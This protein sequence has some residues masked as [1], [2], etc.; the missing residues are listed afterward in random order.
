MVYRYAFLFIALSGSLAAVAQK[1]TT[2]QLKQVDISDGKQGNFGAMNQVDGMMIGAGKKTEIISVEQL[3]V[4]K[5]TNNTRQ[6]YAKVAGL[7][8][9]END[10]SGLQLS[11]GGRGLDPNRTSNFN[12]RQNG[13]DISADALGYPESYYT[14]PT[15]ALRRIEIIKGAASLQYGTQF[16]GLLNFEMKQPEDAKKKLMVESRQTLGSWGFFGSFNSIGGTSADGKVSYYAFAQYKRGDGWR[17]NSGFQ[18]LNVYGDVHYHVNEKHMFG[19][20]YTHLQYLAQQPGGLDDRMFAADPRQSNR[21]RNWFAVKWN[22][23]DLEWDYRIS[24]RTRWQTR[25]Y[26]L[27]A[28]R[29][30][31]GF[32]PNRPAQPD[33]GGAR[34]LLMG[35]FQNVAM[36]SKVL[37]SYRAGKQ[38]QTLLTGVR[39]YNGHSTNRQGYVNNGSGARFSFDGEGTQMLSDYEFPN[40][41]LAW[42]AEHIVRLN[43]KWQVTPGIRVEHIRTQANGSYYNRVLDLRD[44]IVS[45]QLVEERRLLPRTF[46]IAGIGSGYRFSSRLEAYGNISQN[47][48]SVTFSDIR[49]VNPSFEIDPAISDEKG[50]SGDLGIRGNA[51]DVFRFDANVF[52]LY[53]G[54]RIGEYFYTKSNA[55]VVRRRG[56]VGVAQIYGLESFM[57][58]DVLQLWKADKK[59]ALTVYNNLSLTNARYT[60]SPIANIEGRR[61]EYVPFMNWKAGIQAGYKNIKATLQFSSLSEQYADATNAESG[62]YSGVNGIVPAYRLVDLSLSYHYKWLVL[63]GTVNNLANVPYFTRRATGYP[64]PGIIPGDGRGFYLTAGVKL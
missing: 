38:L 48:R 52:Y 43:S 32:R 41:N 16:G 64:G 42:F 18:S 23:L 40:L 15:E 1:D 33:N 63:E 51:H 36:E 30:A 58:L 10:G 2:H 24:P 50:W 3:T 6:V 13:Y 28:S 14:P 60:R 7:N 4:N 27:M 56:N 5:A 22:L 59:F 47:Y 11:I 21:E 26:G 37:T 62:G 31:I 35:T 57:E 25:A 55:Q 45:E 20:E 39:V 12:V 49:V 9:F 46:V 34:D 29:D 17:P 54:N 53:Y 61:V 8:I 44:S 19:I